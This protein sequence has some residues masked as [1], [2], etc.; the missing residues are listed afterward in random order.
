[1]TLIPGDLGYLLHKSGESIRF[2]RQPPPDPN[3]ARD[4]M[5]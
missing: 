3:V 5:Q 2:R 4:N 1:M